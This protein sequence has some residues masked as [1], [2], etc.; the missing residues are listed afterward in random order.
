[1]RKTIAIFMIF[2]ILELPFLLAQEPTIV[3]HKISGS[4]GAADVV[5]QSDILSAEVILSAEAL[6]P[7]Q[8]WL[9]F[10]TSFDSCVQISPGRFKCNLFFPKTGTQTFEPENSYSINVHRIIPSTPPTANTF[11]DSRS[12]SLIIDEYPPVIQVSLQA[13]KVRDTLQAQIMVTDSSS[14]EGRC[15]GIRIIS[16]SA[17]GVT[18]TLD[19]EGQACRQDAAVSLNVTTLSEGQYTLSV[20]ASDHARSGIAVQ[21]PFTVDR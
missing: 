18:K 10:V 13:A 5:R 21:V 20:S 7:M 12:G 16:L 8:V 3:Q 2:L 6:D 14:V 11:S 17:S 4:D 1:M 19:Y 9:G 15:S